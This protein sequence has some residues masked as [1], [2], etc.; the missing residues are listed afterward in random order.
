MAGFLDFLAPNQS[1]LGNIL[2]N[3]G[4]VA[5]FGMKYDDM[6]VRNSQAIGRTEGLFSNE[7]GNGSTSN[8]AFYWT[9]SYQDTK[10]KKY[11]AYFDKDYI[12]KRNYLRKFSLN[13]EIEYILDI[14]TDEAIVYDDRNFFAQPSFVNLDIKEKIK[15]KITSHYNRIYATYGFQNSVLGWQYFR[16]FII[17]GFLAFEIIY[18]S[19][20]KEIIGFKELDAT[21]LQPV[22]EKVGLDEY[23]Q[24]W[25]QYP[26][27]PQMT[28]KLTNEQVIYI[29][30]AKGNQVSRVSYVERLI[31]SYNILRIM[32]NSRII[33]N[34]MNSSY[35]LKFII[36]IGTQSQT[37][38]MQT[39]GQLMSNYKEDININDTSGELTI[40][41]RPKVQ[42]YKN[43][44]FPENNGV[45]PTIETLN[46][47]GPDFNVMDNVL[48]FFNK[49]KMDSKIPYARFAAKS[50]T[51]VNYQTA[52]DQLERDEIRF[53]KFLRRL[54]SNFQEILAKPLFIQMCLDYPELAK[55]RNF[56]ANIGL[57]FNKDSEFED[58]VEL[59]NF[60][61]RSTFITG[62]GGL[63][64]KVG[65]ED[66]PYFDKDFLIQRFLGMNPDQL[67][68]NKKYKE[69][70]AKEVPAPAGAA[71]AEGGAPPAAGEPPAEAG[72]GEEKA[73]EVTF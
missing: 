48:Y 67:N 8:D 23:Q 69:K 54:R 4:D 45:S 18:D 50:G 46:A 57:I 13:G 68:M 31:R 37:K 41:G 24:F 44:L 27:N 15:E 49:L 3:L 55:D 36:P 11:I 26:A 73:P 56:R 28:R 71:P 19:K 32:E 42:F 39:L 51:P 21:S 66:K 14:I 59:D 53:G 34:V 9:A 5:K 40:N 1:A 20:G 35:R 12:D 52:I 29:S 43:Y 70:E 30:Y 47:N 17:D 33:W 58:L 6:V 60:T 38:A 16:Q 22:V 72:G 2:R 64:T 62:L 7:S 25:I 61:K 10:V 63:V 65:E